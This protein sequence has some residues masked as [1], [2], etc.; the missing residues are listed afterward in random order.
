MY[1]LGINAYH[2]DS[3]AALLKDGELILAIEEERFSRVKHWAGFPGE[4]IW[5]CLQEEGISIRKILDIRLL[6]CG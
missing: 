1:I 5:F 3:S 6:H 4:A 2:A